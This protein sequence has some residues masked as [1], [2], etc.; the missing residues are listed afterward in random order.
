VETVSLRNVK[1]NL[2]FVLSGSSL[3]VRQEN[4]ACV[5]QN[6]LSSSR[7]YLSSAYYGCDFKILDFAGNLSR[8][9]AILDTLYLARCTGL[10]DNSDRALTE[11]IGT[12]V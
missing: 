12:V 7:I 1:I 8:T 3:T 4:Y 2:D 10:P 6:L 11:F 9:L 5:K